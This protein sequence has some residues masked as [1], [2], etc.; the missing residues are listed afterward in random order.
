MTGNNKNNDFYTFAENKIAFQTF[1]NEI[2][3]SSFIKKYG[4]ILDC[5]QNYVLSSL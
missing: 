1:N 4:R 2:C 5:Q 3:M